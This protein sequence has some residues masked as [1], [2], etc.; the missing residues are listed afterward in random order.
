L[1]RK[2][3]TPLADTR[4]FP[5]VFVAIHAECHWHTKVQA[6]DLNLETILIW[7]GSANRGNGISG[8]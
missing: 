3:F 5:L 6:D 8:G 4:Q 2:E 1:E 7:S